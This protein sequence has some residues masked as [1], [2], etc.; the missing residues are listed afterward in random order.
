[1]ATLDESR[2]RR[3][4]EFWAIIGS[5]V[6]IGALT[7]TVSGWHRSDM[8]SLRAQIGGV[9]DELRA[10]IG[11]V[12]AEIGGVRAEIGG[13]RAEM[14]AEIGG[15]RAEIG[16]VRGEIAGVRGE[17][18]GVRGEIRSLDERLTGRIDTLQEGQAQ[19]FARLA[20]LESHVLG[21]APV[22]QWGSAAE[23]AP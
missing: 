20:V 15:V 5:A 21:A 8:E 16:G 2:P 13:V 23:P 17:I 19:I 22:A 12:R 18:A 9:R 3:S 7:L 14:R 4:S 10:E 1:M 11:G 6:A